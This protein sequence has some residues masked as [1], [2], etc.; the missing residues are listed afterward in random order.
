VFY[1]FEVTIS[2]FAELVGGVVDNEAFASFII[3]FNA[4]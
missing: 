3:G 4:V 2:G 1:E